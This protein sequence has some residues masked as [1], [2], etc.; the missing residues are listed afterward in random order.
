[1]NGDRPRRR[2]RLQVLE[3]M[4]MTQTGPRRGEQADRPPAEI[5][6]LFDVL[7][8]QDDA[9]RLLDGALTRLREV[10]QAKAA[11]RG[12]SAAE[13]RAALQL[14]RAALGSEPA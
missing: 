10:Q 7:A 9:I 2:R 14:R 1:M 3:V 12:L 8:R 13:L 4:T 11:L 5:V 6:R